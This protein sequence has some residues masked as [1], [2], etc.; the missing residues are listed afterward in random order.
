[1]QILHDMYHAASGEA[2]KWRLLSESAADAAEALQQ[3]TYET[4]HNDAPER[5]CT[6][7]RQQHSF[8]Q[9]RTH[10]RVRFVSFFLVLSVP[11]SIA[12]RMQSWRRRPRG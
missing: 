11:C 3:K 6:R 12:F 8:L 7:C 5:V 10:L 4:C 1:M 2:S 9:M